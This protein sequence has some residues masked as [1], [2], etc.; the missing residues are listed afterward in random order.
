MR[1]R[2]EASDAML[3]S[4]DKELRDIGGASLSLDEIRAL[5]RNSKASVLR[6]TAA[7]LFL[8]ALE[9]RDGSTHDIS[10]IAN[11]IDGRAKQS[12]DVNKSVTKIY[13]HSVREALDE[14][15]AELGAG[16]TEPGTVEVHTE[17]VTVCGPS[18][19]GED[20]VV[21]GEDIP[22]GE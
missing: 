17:G 4:F 18:G 5:A 6:R 3:A 2:Q 19:D 22:V 1:A 7:I 14:G 21:P 12:I 20:A 9:D 16:T 8:R 11:R 15:L 13:T 10:L